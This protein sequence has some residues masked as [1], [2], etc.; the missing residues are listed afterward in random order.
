MPAHHHWGVR[1]AVRQFIF[2]DLAK[3]ITT[4]SQPPKKKSSNP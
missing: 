4:Q 1:V 3:P 2:L